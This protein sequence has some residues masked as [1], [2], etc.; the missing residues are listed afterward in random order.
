MSTTRIKE[1]LS[2]IVSS[3]LPEFIQSDYPTFVAFI[4]AYYK[5]LEQDQG[6]FELLQNARSYA[7]VD[8]TIPSFVV[9]F[10]NQYA[11]NLPANA[12]VNKKLFVKKIKD[13]YESKGSETSFKLLFQIL[14]DKKVSVT[15]PYE[16][17]LR[18]S[19]GKWQQRI[20]LRLETVSGNRSGLTNKTLRYVSNSIL[21][22]TQ[23]TETKLL[24]PTLIEVFLNANQAAPLYF[25]GDTVEVYSGTQQ[26]FKGIIRP[27]TVDYKVL[28]SGT[29]FRVGQVININYSGGIGTLI[30][31]TELTVNKGVQKIQFINYG[32]NYPNG[33]T[34]FTVDLSATRNLSE[35]S[36]VNSSFTQGFG[37]Q[38]LVEHVSG[39]NPASP[40][41][42]FDTDYVITDYT[43]ISDFRGFNNSTYF[44]PQFSSGAKLNDIATVQFTLGALGKYPGSYFRNDGFLSEAD[45]R[46]EDSLLYQPFAYLTRTEVDVEEFFDVV[47]TLIH[48]AGERLFNDRLIEQAFDFSANVVLSPESNIYFEARSTATVGDEESILFLKPIANAEGIVNVEELANIGVYKPFA[49]IVES[50]TDND[51]I[52][53]GKRPSSEVSMSDEITLVTING[54][55]VVEPIIINESTASSITKPI[56]NND[57]IVSITDSGSVAAS[58][59]AD[60]NRY[61]EEDYQIGIYTLPTVVETF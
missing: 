55:Q 31:I 32:Y 1:K 51:T 25:V 56:N 7:D 41:R 52:L 8:T 57:S 44:T 26:I 34:T 35:T 38:G 12:L 19:D 4:E 50:I 37:S 59:I 40:A 23:I 18:A 15:Y 14:F 22:S 21:Y 58:G 27:T 46:L 2:S 24:T 20:S 30:K 10:L 29:G 17:V 49:D 5:F 16:N 60:P 6:A 61:F 42:Y 43:G 45:V 13:L 48:P 47:K 36:D 9:Y 33:D 3:Q 39:Y 28:T 11:P 53:V 54:I